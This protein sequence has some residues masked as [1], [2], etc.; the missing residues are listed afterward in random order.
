MSSP[1]TPID[2]AP[3]SGIGERRG[4]VEDDRLIM[5]QGRYLSDIDPGDALEA[6]FV[7]SPHAHARIVGIDVSRALALD[8]VITVYTGADLQ[9]LVGPWQ[10]APPIP[11][12][13]PTTVTAM[14][15]DKVRFHGD[16][17]ACVIGADRYVCE[18][19]AELV[20]VTYAPLPAVIRPMVGGPPGLVRVDDQVEDNL[21]CEQTHITGS[22]ADAVDSADH[23]ERVTF[24]QARQTHVP[25]EGRGCIATWNPSNTA[26]TIQTGTQVPHGYRSTIAARLGIDES[27]VR[28]VS[29]DVGGAFGQKLVPYREDVCV[30]VISKDLRRTIRWREDRRENMLAALNSREDH[31]DVDVA[32]SSTGMIAGMRASLA[33]DI[34]AYS[35]FPANYMIQV[36][37]MLLPSF[38]L[39]E[40]YEYNLKVFL[41]NKTPAGPYRAPMA[42]ATWVTE[43]VIE[44]VATATGIDSVTI[45]RL[46]M[47]DEA[48]LPYLSSTG[49]LYT[50]ISPRLTLDA[51][52]ERIDY[53]ALRE[54]QA[55][56]RANGELVGLGIAAVLEPTTYGSVFY[57][58]AGIPGSG[59]ESAVVRITPSGGVNLTVGVA[60]SGQ[61]YETMLA[62]VAVD[63]LGA[64]F[65]DIRVRLGD[66]DTSPY[67]MGSRGARVATAAGGAAVLACQALKRKVLRIAAAWL[68]VD[69][70]Q[71]DLHNSTVVLTDGGDRQ[72]TELSL[73]DLA[74]RAY[75]DPSNLPPGED[76]GLEVHKSYDPPPMTFS[77]SV[78]CCAVSV[79]RDIGSVTIER[80]LVA[81]DAGTLINPTMAEGQ[82][83]GA[84]SLGLA[85]ARQEQV[86]LA[87]DGTNLTPDLRYY[88]VI[89]SDEVPQD[90][91]L[92][93]CSVPSASTVGGMKG[94]SEGGVMGSIGAFALA[95][96]DAL[97][98]LGVTVEQL[99]L[100]SDAILSLLS[101]GE[102]RS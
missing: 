95:V 56:R 64:E 89:A 80:Y 37:A 17:V 101:R 29:P 16:L 70:D 50:D 21:L 38:Y 92:V 2:P 53:Q 48:Q 7:R 43:G 49:Q 35:L 62:Q 87:E 42:I 71:L 30:S 44:A 46:N 67:G 94:M 22:F 5:G 40:A 61:G 90:V 73:R 55:R 86:V 96:Q 12:L 13:K 1:I 31:V 68:E 41:S 75:L 20:D 25:L 4:R 10:M 69:A 99:P 27:D 36:V 85:G 54:G 57:R 76:P 98:P 52:C 3:C 14:P 63:A 97:A 8:G 72:P 47:L 88:P 82:L 26:L 6:T 34:G 39:V 84:I 77:N 24:R 51:A 66:T 45:R 74:Q 58:D 23:V 33:T 83:H 18:D 59:M 15:V 79:D 60:A 9:R 81:E 100:N 11:G 78:H 93:D 65:D 91:E 28:V 32:F 102:T 19:A